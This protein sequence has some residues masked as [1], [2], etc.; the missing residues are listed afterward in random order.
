M[1]LSQ[2]RIRYFVTHLIS[3]ATV[4]AIAAAVVFLLWHPA[5]LAKA[6][7]VTHIFLLML[8]VDTTLGP[9]LTLAVAKEGKKSLKMDLTIIVILQLL[10][11]GYGLHS[12]AIN[13]PVYAA[14]DTM[15]FD[16]VQASDVPDAELQKASAPY[17]SLTWGRYGWVAVRPIANDQERNERLMKEMGEG[18]SPT[19]Q[20]ALFVPLETQWDN[21]LKEA[22]DMDKLNAFNP[23]ENVQA[24]MQRYPN[25]D[26]WLPLKAYEVD[27]TVLLDS[28]NKQVLGIVDLRPW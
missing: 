19:M 5:P 3:S 16:L 9:L 10:A 2:T 11:L 25:A 13:R 26:K 1:K 4:A 20:P 14:F 24:A 21:M 8:F 12:I 28:K 6:V 27:M 18:V 15:R 7:G 22:A 17:Q 23:S